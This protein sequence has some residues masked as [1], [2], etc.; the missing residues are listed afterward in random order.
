MNGRVVLL[1]RSGCGPQVPKG[2]GCLSNMCFERSQRY[3]TIA[4]ATLCGSPD[5]ALRHGVA[6]MVH[7][8]L[9]ANVLQCSIW[10]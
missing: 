8:V 10:D 2:S 1:N 9:V 6:R 7:I 3:A 5:L 4:L